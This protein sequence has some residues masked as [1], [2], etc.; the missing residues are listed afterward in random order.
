MKTTPTRSRKSAAIPNSRWLAYAT[1]GAASA[2]A[3]GLPDS[4]E[5]TIHYSGPINRLFNRYERFSFQLDQP[6]DFIFLS[7]YLQ[8]LPYYAAF[9]VR[10]LAEAS[11]VG[12]YGNREAYASKLGRGRLVS[13]GPFIGPLRVNLLGHYS[14]Q[15]DDKG[16]GYIGFKFN[17]GRGDQYGWVRIK[18]L[19]PSFKH[20][21][22]LRDYAYGDVGDRIKAGQISDDQAAP[23]EGSL[24]WVALGA[25]GLLAWRP[26][27][28]CFG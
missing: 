10:G 1:A 16:V 7:H 3:C 5:G 28:F 22:I 25:V 18:T 21:F 24:G 9:G 27:R 20:R 4:A 13:S 6:G 23:D 15:F 2:F 19:T 11:V 17:S 12:F 14:A 8:T 26:R